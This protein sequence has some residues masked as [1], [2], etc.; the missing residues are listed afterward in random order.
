MVPIQAF[1]KLISKDHARGLGTDVLRTF[2]G[3]RVNVGR[4]RYPAVRAFAGT[5]AVGR[6]RQ[7]PR[8]GPAGIATLRDGF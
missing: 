4:A 7:A 3:Q 2:G 6:I 5:G 1:D 8:I